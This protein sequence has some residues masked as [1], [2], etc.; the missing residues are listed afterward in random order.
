MILNI[1]EISPIVYGELPFLD[2]DGDGYNDD[3][4]AD[5]GLNC[6]TDILIDA[7][8]TWKSDGEDKWNV[9]LIE[10]VDFNGDEDFND[11]VG[12]DESI[13]FDPFDQYWDDE[14]ATDLNTLNYS[15]LIFVREGCDEK[16]S[17][18][19]F[20]GGLIDDIS[21]PNRIIMTSTNETYTSVTDWDSFGQPGY[22]FS[23]WAEVFMDAL[24]GRRTY[25]NFT[26]REVVHTAIEV[27]ADWN[28]DGYVSMWEAFRYAW[29]NDE[30]RLD[31]SETPWID[32]NDNGLPTY[33]EEHDN[34]DSGVELLSQDGLLAWETYLGFERLRTPDLDGDREVEMEDIETLIRAF[35]DTPS[36]P[37]WNSSLDLHVDDIIDW[38]DIFLFIKMFGKFYSS[39]SQNSST[40]SPVISVCPNETIVSKHETF[41]VNVT[42]TNVT[43]LR[44]YDF[45]LCYNPTI[46][47]C[48]GVQ[49]PP[50]H[51]LEPLNDP[52][53]I[54]TVRLE[55]D[56]TFNFTHGRVWVA[57]ALFRGEPG[58]NGSGTL[59]TIHF[60][61]TKEGS[62]ILNIYYTMLVNSSAKAMPSIVIDGSV[63]VLTSLTVLA[64]D[65]NG[66]NLTT[67]DVYIDDQLV[68][69]TG[70]TFQVPV[71]TH[72]V[73]VSQG[74]WEY[75]KT[76]CRYGFKN[77]TD[78]A[79]DNP[80]NVTVA[81]DTTITAC[82]NKK[83]C[84]GDVN[85][86]GKVD[87]KDLYFVIY[88]FGSKRGDDLWDS[89]ADLVYDGKIDW[90]DQYEVM[91][92]FGNDYSDP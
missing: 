40:N 33:K 7:N 90:K 28:N 32:D 5:I 73:G 25:Y 37:G 62:S 59:A 24:N 92:N 79:V 71:G 84:P 48:T 82:F 17:F 13:I 4:F 68:G 6:T 46:L 44:C 22:G 61:A 80:R 67:G 31:G 65:Q 2:V 49:L 14:L 60:K 8:A 57:I 63:T 29:Y 11:W 50:G 3:L 27:D 69:Y 23:E 58:K 83:W 21:A 88:R 75:N 52:N 55:Y 91:K 77:W 70:S 54:V 42:V 81:E 74:F 30:A 12:V 20:S 15:R 9:G 16:R 36:K 64:Q 89:R 43:D 86:D 38:K 41:S 87:W 76:G 19:C 39:S 26:T 35:G 47:N 72:K 18:G 10:G 51:F 45:R 53:N 56:N 66:T 1:D 85:G 34:L 78:G